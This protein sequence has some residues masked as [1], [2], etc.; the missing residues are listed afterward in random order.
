MDEGDMVLDPREN[1]EGAGAEVNEGETKADDPAGAAHP[2]S[3]Q[4][5]PEDPS[6]DASQD[7]QTS[8]SK[9]D[10][11]TLPL[12]T[13]DQ[14][15]SEPE[16]KEEESKAVEAAKE[17]D[18]IPV[19]KDEKDE[20]ILGDADGDL[21]EEMEKAEE[22]GRA[23]REAKEKENQAE[24][25]AMDVDEDVAEQP[26]AE[27]SNSK[28]EDK[29]GAGAPAAGE[30]RKRDEDYEGEGTAEKK[31]RIDDDGD[32]KMDDAPQAGVFP[33]RIIPY[34]R[35][36]WLITVFNSLPIDSFDSID[37]PLPHALH[38][39]TRALYIDNFRRP[40]DVAEL[41]E[42]LEGHGTLES[43]IGNDGIWVSGVKSH[44]YCIVSLASQRV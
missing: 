18:S 33:L 38:P 44:V 22:A 14:P 21:G 20:Q 40:L 11:E 30:K 9:R 29:Q 2:A 35:I 24:G 41:R 36:R 6:F 25:G 23:E 8:P 43:T 1:G 17:D 16:K 34:S 39:P 12:S 19:T 7:A 5:N 3:K 42:L 15:A 10:P 27:K 28:G 4:S 31:A 32:V 26:V 37:S 13:E